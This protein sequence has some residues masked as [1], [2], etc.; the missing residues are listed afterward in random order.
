MVEINNKNS[1]NGLYLYGVMYT[2]IATVYDFVASFGKNSKYDIKY[3]NAM[4][5]ARADFSFDD[6]DFI[7]V[8]YCC[9]L[10]HPDH[11]S[12]DALARLKAYAGLKILIVQDEA[13][14]TE[15]VRRRI[16][17]LGFDVVLT[18]VAPA[19]IP[20]IYPPERFPG[21][22]FVSVLPGY[23]PEIDRP[24]RFI[25]PLAERPITVG[26]RG[27]D[28]GFGYG[29]LGYW[30]L[31]V[32]RKTRAACERRK[33]VCDIDWTEDSRIYGEDWYAFTGAC[34]ATLGS[35]SGANAFDDDGSIRAH[36]RAWRAANPDADYFAYR[37]FIA[38]QEDQRR[39]EAISPRLFEAAA[40]FT[41]MILVEGDY[42]GILRPEEHYIPLKGDFSNM[43]AVLDRLDDLDALAAMAERAHRDL[44]ASGAYGYPRFVADIDALIAKKRAAPQRRRGD[45][46][47]NAAP[48]PVHATAVPDHPLREEFTDAP[49]MS[50]AW[51]A[52]R[53]AALRRFAPELGAVGDVPGGAPCFIYGTGG[54]GR[55]LY[56]ALRAEGAVDVAGFI[57]SRE[58][59]ELEGLPV[60]AAAA[61]LETFRGDWPT[62]IIASCYVVEIAEVLIDGGMRRFFD[63]SG[64][65]AHL[66]TLSPA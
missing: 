27:R 23:A 62:V 30:K 10:R 4:C 18:C 63:A 13:D 48:P 40:L 59:G 50:A 35:Q 15:L 7:I 55:T 47:Q 8:G 14:N 51:Q 5:A 58:A 22:E 37:P 45:A 46:G 61:F 32:G 65:V 43:D 44:I 66:A 20:S 16:V 41:P 12:R 33:I 53:D 3:A 36:A 21:V 1:I 6:F 25:R 52:Q 24:E 17:E 31:E 26:Y 64:L 60:Y 42:R 57:D 39:G 54:G 28:I 38:A 19:H 9:S 49:M 11:A 34:R 2:H 29:D 56:A